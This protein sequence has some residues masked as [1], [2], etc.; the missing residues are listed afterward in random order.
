MSNGKNYI[1]VNS[2][3]T[4]II[5]FVVIAARLLLDLLLALKTEAV[6]SSETSADFY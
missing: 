5:W 2:L 1:L 3:N 4:S 6:H